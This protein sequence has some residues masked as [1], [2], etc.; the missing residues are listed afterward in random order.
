MAVLRKL[1]NIIPRNSLLT[2]YKS[3]TPPIRL[4]YYGDIIYQQHNNGI[5]CQKID[6]F[7]ISSSISNKSVINGTSQT[8]LCNELGIESIKLKKW[9]KRLCFAFFFKIRSS[10]LPQYLNELM[11]KMSKR[12][13]PLP[14]FKVRTKIFRNS[15][16]PIY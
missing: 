16:F 7:S 3:Y 4:W 12:F 2:T 9:L 1:Q 5:F 11:P 6:F 15:F 10:G 8:E 13:S 14:N